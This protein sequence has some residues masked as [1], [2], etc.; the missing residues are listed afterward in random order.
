MS[1]KSEKSTE[2][3][4]STWTHISFNLV[5]VMLPATYGMFS[6]HF[7]WYYETEVLLPVIFV[8]IAN[9]LFLLWDA[10]ND[11]LVG[12]ISDRPNRL[13]KKYGRRFPFIAIFGIP[14]MVSIILLFMP[15]FID[16]QINPLPIFLWIIIILF[17]H[18]LSYTAVSLT[19]ALYP[20]KFRSDQERRKNAGIGILTYN[21]GLFLGLIVPMIFVEKGDIQSYWIGA[22]VLMIPCVI[23]F[24][25]GLSGVRED[26]KMIER[27]FEI[28]K[29][30][31]FKTMKNTFKRKNFLALIVVSISTQAFGACILG[32]IYYWVNFVLL[33]P[34][35][36]II[37]MLSWFLAGLISVPFWM[38]INKK[39]GNRNTQLMAI[40][41]TMGSIIPFIFISSLTGAIIAIFILGFVGGAGTFVRYPIFSDLI[42]EATTLDGKRQE[43]VYQ[44]VLAFFDRF[45]I[46]FQPIIFT[47]VHLITRFEPESATQTILAQ[48]GI[49]AAMTWIPAILV[50]IAGIIFW[51]VY[52]LTPEK[53]LKIKSQLEEL[54][55]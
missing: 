24:F 42:D 11:P 51:K 6:T 19:R 8:G 45:G 14:T 27:S 34:N 18:E 55:L 47:I 22:T 44:G 10:F 49:I 39:I 23:F 41:T 4:Y 9:V 38:K 46:L 31:F 2:K 29:E 1:D 32:S 17:I 35:A 54:K 33:E 50:L 48:Q 43:G 13:T 7:F 40:I 28:K 15:P 5:M 16:A 20:E 37:I 36:D 21:M 30:P 26:K 3:K 52:D 25:L 12:F 53:T